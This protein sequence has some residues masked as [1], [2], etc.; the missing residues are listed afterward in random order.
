MT[1]KNPKSFRE[2]SKRQNIVEK[3]LYYILTFFRVISYSS[4]SKLKYK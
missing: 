1:K 2:H 4:D 3:I